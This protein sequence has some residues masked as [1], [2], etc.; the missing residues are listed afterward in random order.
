VEEGTV[1][2]PPLKSPDGVRLASLEQR[3][4]E[5]DTRLA[6][7]EAQSANMRQDVDMLAE[8]TGGL[9]RQSAK[10]REAALRVAQA[11]AIVRKRKQVPTSQGRRPQV[12]KRP[13]RT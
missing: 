1:E 6:H 3:A 10:M 12:E 4:R 9:R 13:P 8:A 7:L 11:L 5:A 2:Q